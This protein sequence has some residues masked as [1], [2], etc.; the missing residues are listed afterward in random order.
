MSFLFVIKT[1]ADFVCISG[2]LFENTVSDVKK[3]TQIHCYVKNEINSLNLVN[4]NSKFE[5]KSK[6]QNKNRFCFFFRTRN[7][8]V[9][10][11]HTVF[12]APYI[13]LKLSCMIN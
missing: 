2:I 7:P 8:I 6:I 9:F 5:C 3:D 10:V 13:V 12:M 1:V 4:Q 11:L